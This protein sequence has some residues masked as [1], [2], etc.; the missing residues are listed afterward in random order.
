MHPGAWDYFKESNIAWPWESV[1]RKSYRSDSWPLTAS[2]LFLPFE[3]SNFFPFLSPPSARTP[4]AKPLPN[5]QTH[6][7]HWLNIREIIRNFSPLPFRV[8]I[9][10][11]SVV[12]GQKPR[13]GH[14]SHPREAV[15]LAPAAKLQH[16][17]TMWCI[18]R[19]VGGTLGAWALWRE[20]P[21]TELSVSNPA[22]PPPGCRNEIRESFALHRD[23]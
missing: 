9:S 1:C 20:V 13:G 5:S 14:I 17:R 18:P 16:Q 19:Q 11:A 2:F 4:T 21:D 12:T 22:E 8:F 15:G 7:E 10:M 23:L 3:E 6:L